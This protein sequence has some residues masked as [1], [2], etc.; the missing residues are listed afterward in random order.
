MAAGVFTLHLQDTQPQA[1]NMQSHV[2]LK[3]YGSG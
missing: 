1:S 3:M 2:L